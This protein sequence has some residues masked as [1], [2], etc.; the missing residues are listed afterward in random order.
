MLNSDAIQR[1]HF[2]PSCQVI[3]I[4]NFSEWQKLPQ[5]LKI[6]RGWFVA[7]FVPDDVVQCSSKSADAQ[8]LQLESYVLN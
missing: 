6:P 8:D 4:P 3:I 2:L 5:E 7:F 1:P